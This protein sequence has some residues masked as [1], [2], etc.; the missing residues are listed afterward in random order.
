MNFNGI[1]G[2]ITLKQAID[3]DVDE[4]VEEENENDNETKIITE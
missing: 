1:E 2:D 4:V 3:F